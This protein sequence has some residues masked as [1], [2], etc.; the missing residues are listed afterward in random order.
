MS[1]PGWMRGEMD[2][3]EQIEQSLW[4]RAGCRQTRRGDTL[5]QWERKWELVPEE[6]DEKHGQRRVI[7]PSYPRRRNRKNS[8]PHKG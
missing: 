2:T 8:K 6:I 5:R 1:M 3:K 4:F 7:R